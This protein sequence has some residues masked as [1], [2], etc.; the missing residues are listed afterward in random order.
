MKHRGLSK[1]V[2]ELVAELVKRGYETRLTSRCHVRVLTRE[3]ATV[4]VFPG[5]PSDV[6]SVRNA[7][8]DV[9]RYERAH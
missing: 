8:A 9:R 7:R 3:G 5:T 2:R 6:R 1:E 4:T